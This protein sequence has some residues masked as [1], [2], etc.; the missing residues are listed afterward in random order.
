MRKRR[1]RCAPAERWAACAATCRGSRV[2]NSTD[3]A[4]Q[5]LAV[6]SGTTEDPFT[7]DLL[8]CY[9]KWIATEGAVQ[10][11]SR[12][13]A[14]IAVGD[15][16]IHRAV[17]SRSNRIVAAGTVTGRPI[18]RGHGRW[19]WRLPRRL[20][21]VCLTLDVAPTAAEPG[22]EAHGVRTYKELHQT[23]GQRA[24]ERLQRTGVPFS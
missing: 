5:V 24:A 20:T 15:V 13:P 1:P 11:F 23:A 6:N 12:R 17:G 8:S 16:L 18:D 21:F 19:P 3:E 10:G 9:R 14:S 2:V 4:R 22:I 7:G